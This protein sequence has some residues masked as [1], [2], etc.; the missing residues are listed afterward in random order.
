MSIGGIKRIDGI[1]C[2]AFFDKLTDFVAYGFLVVKPVD[3]G[4]FLV[5]SGFN[6]LLDTIF[7]MD[8]N[9]FSFNLFGSCPYLN[10]RHS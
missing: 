5:G 9:F 8:I 6:E 3:L 1:H 2:Y 10:Q 4:I 7:S